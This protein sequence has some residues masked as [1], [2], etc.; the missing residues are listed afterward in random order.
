[1]KNTMN[2]CFKTFKSPGFDT[3]LQLLKVLLR[4]NVTDKRVICFQ[5]ND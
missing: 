3:L 4:E 5:A 2:S 1:V